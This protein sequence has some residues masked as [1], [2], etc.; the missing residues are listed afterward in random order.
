MDITGSITGNL[1]GSVGSVTGA[2]GSVTGAV[3][4][5]TGL[6]ASDVGAIKT[7]TDKL[8]FTVANQVDSNVQ[9]INDVTLVGDGVG[10]PMG[11]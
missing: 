3:G 7:Q 8:T 10:T 11:A 4:S 2:V 5:V 9:S 6:T 1:S